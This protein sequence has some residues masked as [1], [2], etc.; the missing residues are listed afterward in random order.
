MPGNVRR[1]A[2]ISPNSKFPA[3]FKE[4]EGTS[5]NTYVCTHFSSLAFCTI[6]T[7]GRRLITRHAVAWLPCWFLSDR[8][9]IIDCSDWSMDTSLR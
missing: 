9:S 4:L 6:I 7:R 8:C 2:W 5:R 1:H 3:N